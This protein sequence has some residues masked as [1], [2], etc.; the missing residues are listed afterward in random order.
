MKIDEYGIV[1]S[2][3][4][5]EDNDYFYSG[6]RADSMATTARWV[7]LLF[8]SFRSSPVVL[9]KFVTPTGYRSH[10]SPRMSLSLQEGSISSDT[11]LP[12]FI[13]AGF[14]LHEQMR[15]RLV[16]NYFRTGDSKFVS[17]CLL[18]SILRS[19]LLLNICIIVQ[20]LI[21]KTP[22]CKR[23]D[24]LNWTHC[25]LNGPKWIRRIIH[26][27]TVI[28]NITLYYKPTDGGLI[29][30]NVDWLVGLYKQVIK[31]NWR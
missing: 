17:T 4:Y 24:Y 23:A 20:A 3:I 21:F 15:T 19:Q 30:L 14:V 27:D 5:P 16:N 28:D 12:F 29:E 9:D 31:E 26:Q 22:W 25:A 7:D 18:S 2:E 10:P 13:A 11:A 6:N 1:V 8:H